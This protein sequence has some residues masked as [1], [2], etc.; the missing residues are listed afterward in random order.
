MGEVTEAT[1]LIAIYP[2]C[3]SSETPWVV[4]KR[5]HTSDINTFGIT[6]SF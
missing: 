5:K 3:S 2:H 4:Q 1:E 6:E